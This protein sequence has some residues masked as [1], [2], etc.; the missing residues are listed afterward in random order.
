MKE[1]Q[2]KMELEKT[3][4][5]IDENEADGRGWS[6]MVDV[7]DEVEFVYRR[8]MLVPT[9][10]ASCRSGTANLEA[11]PARAGGASPSPARCAAWFTGG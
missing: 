5:T 11:P 4:M 9:P 7:A 6:R 10:A 1:Q 8:G 2:E 3:K